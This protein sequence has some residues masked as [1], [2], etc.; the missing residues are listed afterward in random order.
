MLIFKKKTK[1]DKT[2]R[3]DKESELYIVGGV[4]MSQAFITHMMKC[5][6]PSAPFRIVEREDGVI[7]FDELEEPN[8]KT[9]E[10]EKS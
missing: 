6:L 7:S 2:V 3:Y 1:F 4:K 8:K 9:G 10:G 5:K